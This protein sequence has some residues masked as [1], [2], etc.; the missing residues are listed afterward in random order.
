MMSGAFDVPFRHLAFDDSRVRA[1][2]SCW[3]EPMTEQR[4]GVS[5]SVISVLRGKNRAPL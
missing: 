1:V 3:V 2:S 4:D 5:P